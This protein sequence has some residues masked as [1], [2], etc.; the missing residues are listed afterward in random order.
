MK[1]ILNIAHYE[2]LHI[3]KD[4][5]L[6]L[7][8]FIV[9]LVYAVLF[10]VVYCAGILNDI[11]IAIVDQDNTELSREVA[12][13]FANSP[14]FKV[15][16]NISSYSQLQQ[17]MNRGTVRAGVVIPADFA[18]KVAEHR[19]AEVLTV[20]DSSNLVYGYNIRKYALEITNQFNV[21]YTARNLAGLGLSQQEI[22]NVMDAVSCNT[23]VWY[24]PTFSYVNFLY[25]GLMMMV[26][27]QIGFL[28]I[29]LTVTRE[30]ERGCWINY[31]CAPISRVKIIAGKCLPY[32]ITNFFN[33]LLLIWF[34]SV[35]IHA[36]IEGSLFLIILLGLIYDLI[37]TLAGFFI[38]VQAP[39]SLQVTR[40]LMLLSVPF[41]LISGYTWPSSHMPAILNGIA[42]L[43]P[44]TWMAEGFRLTTIKGLGIMQ[45]LPNVL[46]LSIMA[47]VAI[48]L[49]LTFNKMRTMPDES[50]LTVNCGRSYPRR[51]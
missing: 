43:L 34:S 21:N 37:I 9:P 1:Q 48:I 4:P 11:P 36:K 39:N 47:A 23:S 24:N 25:M 2:V 12:Q 42:R 6:F 35:F 20:Y 46:V 14:Q 16:E 28:S 18:Q 31:L 10:G 49:A 27:H 13:A 3:F 17:G 50:G 8:V 29:S 15:V 30:K 45:I 41:F 19:H 26:I 40:Y 33:Y 44:F 5:I 22:T 32:F 38:S 7:I 51:R